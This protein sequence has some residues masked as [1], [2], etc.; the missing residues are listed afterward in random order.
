MTSLIIPQKFNFLNV[1][2]AKL[3]HSKIKLL[4]IEIDGSLNFCQ[5]KN[6]KF[7]NVSN[8]RTL[9]LFNSQIENLEIENLE[10]DNLQFIED[11][12][13]CTFLMLRNTII[14]NLRVKNRG[15]FSWKKSYPDVNSLEEVNEFIVISDCENSSIERVFNSQN[16]DFNKNVVKSRKLEVT[17]VIPFSSEKG[18]TEGCI[19]S[20]LSPSEESDLS[21]KSEL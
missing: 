6:L 19:T 15:N 10:I 3:S 4:E 18:I 8:S 5:I 1:D 16:F 7:N 20:L 9:V 14:K 17:S 21:E 11:V 12:K 13:K 2:R